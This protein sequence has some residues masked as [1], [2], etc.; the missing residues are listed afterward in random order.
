[1]T[2]VSKVAAFGA[3]AAMTATGLVAA[4]GTSA[5]AADPITKTYSCKLPV[6]D[7]FPVKVDFTLPA[8]PASVPA[9]S[10]V[11]SLPVSAKMTLTLAEV[12]AI[13][14][15]VGPLLGSTP[16]AFGGPITGAG[17]LG[18]VPVPMNLT[19]PSTPISTTGDTVLP[20][21]G[22]TEAFKVPTAA[23]TYDFSLPQ[24]ITAQ[25]LGSNVPGATCTVSAADA[26]VSSMKVTSAPAKP[27]KTLSVSAPKKAKLGHVLKVKVVTNQT[28]KAVAKIK[29]KKVASAT[30]KG[31]KAT[32]KIKKG[33]K[34]GTDKIVVSVGSLKKTVKVKVTK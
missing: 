23:G 25:L 29:G 7:A 14:T 15:A 9:G 22:T 10:S 24:S 31:G 12:S 27:A 30:V 8:L 32:L 4:T 34:K 2:F 26:K 6:G 3:A 17:S 11:P 20:A 1:M 5:I 19:V 16:T 13:G 18:S 33:L 21:S 28:G